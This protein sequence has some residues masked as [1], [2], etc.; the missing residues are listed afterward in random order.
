MS[1]K[2][3]FKRVALATVAAMGFGLLSVVPA[4]A[5][6]VATAWI[7]KSS[8]IATVATTQ[9]TNSTAGLAGAGDSI[10]AMTAPVGAAIVFKV[11]S[12]DGDAFATTDRHYLYINGQ[13]M[14][15]T[16]GTAAQTNDVLYQN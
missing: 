12:A 16:A 2:T 5:G 8:T 14:S 9:G 7:D 15:V 1:T 13:Q 6:V 4:N 11:K 10:T 3:T